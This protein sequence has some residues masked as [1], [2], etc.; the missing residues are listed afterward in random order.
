MAYEDA[1]LCRDQ[2]RMIR[3]VSSRQKVDL[4]VPDTSCDLFGVHESERAV[5]MTVMHFRE[6]LLMGT[7][8]FVIP[9]PSWELSEGERDESVV[10]FYMDSTLDIPAEI[11]LPAERGFHLDELQ[12]YF[13]SRWPGQVQ[14][15]AP[16]R[17]VKRALVELAEK[18]AR[19]YLLQKAPYSD[20]DAVDDLQKALA[21]PHA[22]RVIE[23]FDIS[24]LGSSFAVSGMVRF[25]DGAPDKAGY[26]R[27][28]IKSVAGQDDFAMLMEA[29]TRRL[30]RLQTEQR[31]FPDLLLIDGGK[32]QLGAVL[33]ALKAF[34]EPP[35]AVSLA[36]QEELLHSPW[37]DSEVRL[38]AAH[39]AR[40]LVERVRDEVHRYSLTYHRTL[41]GKQF[42]RSLLEDI[43]GVGPATA[44]ALLRTFGSVARLRESSVEEMAAVKGVSRAAAEAVAA[45]LRSRR[46]D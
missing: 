18:N 26:R 36:K 17:G 35:M 9:R 12:E 32:G 15:H 43:P 6:G 11:L 10:R 5:C 42:K 20:S 1:A 22:P 16:Q 19:L 4:A 41:R 38:P 27:F 40:R 25:V 24:N 30:S 37:V 23:A 14:V 2:I 13:E 39:P 7:R 34:D 29:V 3:D 31:P 28:R 46:Q 21:L 33:E 45:V 44:R 8:N